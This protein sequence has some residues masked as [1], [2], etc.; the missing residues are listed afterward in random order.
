MDGKG[1]IRGKRYIFLSMQKPSTLN[2]FLAAG[3]LLFCCCLGLPDHVHAQWCYSQIIG[4]ELPGRMPVPLSNNAV[5]GARD[6]SGAYCYYS[7]TGI[8]STLVRSGI[9]LNAYKHDGTSWTSLPPVPD[10][11]GKIAAAAST[12]GNKI[13]VIGGYHVLAGGAER[14]SDRVHVFDPQTESWL[15]DGAAIPVPIDDHVQAVYRDSLIYVVTGWSNTTNVPNVQIYNPA[16]DQWEAGTPV[17]DDNQFKAFGASGAIVGDTLYY[18]GGARLG[19]DFPIAGY[20]RKGVIDPSDPTQIAWSV[21]EDSN[22]ALY[23][24]AAS[25]DLGCPQADNP[26]PNVFWFGG[27]AVTYNYNG[28][29]YNGSGPVAPLQDFWVQSEL[30][31]AGGDGIRLYDGFPPD[32]LPALMDLRG[33]IKL[34]DPQDHYV[35]LGGMSEG[36]NV[37][38]RGYLLG[39]FIVGLPDVQAGALDIRPTVTRGPVQIRPESIVAMAPAE[40]S[41]VDIHGRVVLRQQVSPPANIDL[42]GQQPGIY[43]VVLARDGQRWQGRVV[44]VR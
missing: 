43:H 35:L 7:F 26:L 42:S 11:L 2:T 39:A 37:D 12:V 5:A 31:G 14:S 22:A 23:R 4:T 44:V 24:A 13:Y 18:A 10:T 41:V 17:P 28:V 16:L 9:R 25:V 32:D 27:S 3:Y 8:D 15:A 20:L 19:F 29:A 6:G 38:G 34:P 21:A 40:L 33:M 36:R 1:M 30:E